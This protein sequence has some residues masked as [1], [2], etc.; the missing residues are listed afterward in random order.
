MCVCAG[1]DNHR[2]HGVSSGG[3]VLGEQDDLGRVSDQG[4]SAVSGQGK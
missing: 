4:Q 2:G 1:L 3:L